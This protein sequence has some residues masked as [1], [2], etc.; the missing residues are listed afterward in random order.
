MTFPG[1]SYMNVAYQ[2]RGRTP[3]GRR[4]AFQGYVADRGL[5]LARA[6]ASI[7]THEGTSKKQYG[8]CG[9]LISTHRTELKV[10]DSAHEEDCRAKVILQTRE[11][12][13]GW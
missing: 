8:I 6:L 11:T 13:S 1:F 9:A 12:E 4:E 2:M 7:Q 3:F 5:I 10:L